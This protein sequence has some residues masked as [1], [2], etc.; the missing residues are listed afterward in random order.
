MRLEPLIS[1]MKPFNPAMI[2]K[3]FFL[4][5]SLVCFSMAHG[6]K[7]KNADSLAYYDDLFNELDNFIDS[8][9]APRTMFLVNV[10]VSSNFLNYTA[11]DD[12]DLTAQRRII[13]SPSIGYY[14][15][16]GL[17]INTSALVVNDEGNLNP[18]QFM[19]TGSYD[20]INNS[21]FTTGISGTHYF[22]K[23]SLSFY[24]SPL[25]NEVGAYFTYRKMWLKPSL[26]VSYGWGSRSDYEEREEYITSLRL[27][28]AGYTRIN[29]EEKIND[30]SLTTSVRH[31]FY[32]L[33]LLGENRVLRLTPQLVF[34]SGTQ[35]FGFNQSTSSAI[36]TKP[37]GKRVV[38][39]S[40]NVQLDDNVTFQPLSLTAFIKSEL[41]FGKFFIQ[42]QIAFDYYFP[43]REKNFNT[44]FVFNAGLI[45]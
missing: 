12:V 16:S 21:A 4:A 38:Y 41:S 25:Q 32:W 24:T 34:V 42:P 8:I 11:K 19:V 14:H 40:Q 28:P 33:D 36:S 44:G 9:T 6:Q 23:D 18:Y 1:N 5:T 13:F 26:S 7:I 31:D 20:Y 29:T 43:G 3:L 35:K 10:G 45:F 2:K 30:F 17:G 27:R 15:K 22:T 39:D 37:N